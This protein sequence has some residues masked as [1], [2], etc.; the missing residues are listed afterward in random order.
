LPALIRR[1]DHGSRALDFG[2]GTGRSTRLL[3]NLGLN[4]IGADISQAMLD[5]ARALDPSGEYHL[6]RGN[7]SGEFAP[8]SF[9]IILA[10]LRFDNMPTEANADALSGLRTL[11]AP[12]GC[13]LLLFLQPQSRSTGHPLARGI[14]QR[15]ATQAVVIGSA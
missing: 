13:L 7:I 15:I 6:V 10:A 12:D 8:G 2:C 1:Y 5:Q 14:F 3:R 4:V 11:L 9:D